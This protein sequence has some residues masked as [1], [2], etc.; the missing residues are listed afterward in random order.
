MPSS[1]TETAM[2]TMQY[3][4]ALPADYDMAI[5]RKRIADRGH[6]TDALPQLAFKA[7]LYADRRRL[8]PPGARIATHRF[9]FGAIRRA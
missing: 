4:I 3:R 1:F 7:Y 8:T 2:L 6:L 9:I 5:I